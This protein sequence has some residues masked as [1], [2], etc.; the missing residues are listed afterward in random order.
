MLVFP[1]WWLIDIKL[2]DNGEVLYKNMIISNQ[3]FNSCSWH[4]S[5]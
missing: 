4:S 5:L 1:G 2:T 3:D